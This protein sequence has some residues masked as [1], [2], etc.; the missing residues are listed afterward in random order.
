MH[1]DNS[2]NT[3]NTNGHDTEGLSAYTQQQSNGLGTEPIIHSTAPSDFS[4]SSTNSNQYAFDTGTRH[5]LHS[6]QQ[7]GTAHISSDPSSENLRRTTDRGQ[8]ISF[9]NP[10]S[11]IQVLTE[12]R[13]YTA[14]HMASSVEAGNA[15]SGRKQYCMRHRTHIRYYRTGTESFSLRVIERLQ[16]GY[17]LWREQ[18]I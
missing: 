15:T 14:A 18:Y 4:M 6:H 1:S 12:P 3:G 2:R 9:A 7:F 13:V 8:S 16:I 11:N 10:V 5:N 17:L